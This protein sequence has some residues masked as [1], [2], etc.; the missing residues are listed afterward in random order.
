MSH[1]TYWYIVSNMCLFDQRKAE[2]EENRSPQF[3]Q[4][5]AKPEEKSQKF[6]QQKAKPEENKSQKFA[7]ALKTAA[8]LAKQVC[9]AILLS[10]FPILFICSAKLFGKTCPVVVRCS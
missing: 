7:A 6:D 5:K 2:P 9:V 8:S 10:V 4:Q 1:V 3:D